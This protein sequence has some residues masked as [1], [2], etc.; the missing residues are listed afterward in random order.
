MNENVESLGHE[1]RKMIQDLASI[2]TDTR[3]RVAVLEAAHR[4]IVSECNQKYGTIQA[5]LQRYAE[6]NEKMIYEL[7]EISLKIATNSGK[8]ILANHFITWGLALATVLG[9]WFGGSHLTIGN[10]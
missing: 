8:G 3:E 1:L 5:Q 9:A 4:N 6:Q 7:H 2:S 10:K